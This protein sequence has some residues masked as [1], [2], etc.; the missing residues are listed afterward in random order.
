MEDFSFRRDWKSVVWGPT[1]LVNFFRS[2]AAG[3][4]WFIFSILINSTNPNLLLFPI[5]YFL[6]LLP[7]GLIAGKLGETGVPFAGLFST[8]ISLLVTVGDP[9]VYILYTIKP[10]LIPVE[11]F[12]LFNLRL[13]IFVLQDEALEKIDA[14]KDNSISDE[15]LLTMETSEQ[16][17]F[18]ARK[19]K[20]EIEDNFLEGLKL[21]A[22]KKDANKQ[23]K[24][25]E[26]SLT[27]GLSPQK[28]LIA[29]TFIMSSYANLNNFDKANTEAKIIKDMYG[30]VENFIDFKN[31]PAE[32]L[33]VHECRWVPFYP[34]NIREDLPEEER[35][36]AALDSMKDYH[37]FMGA[38]ILNSY[39]GECY[40]QT[41]NIELA[42]SEF[43][44]GI[45]RFA[46]LVEFAFEV[47]FR[48]RLGILYKLKGDLR[49]AKKEFTKAIEANSYVDDEWFPSDEKLGNKMRKGVKYWL[50]IAE[51][52][53]DEIK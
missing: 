9:L 42:I 39:L 11:K 44:K 30:S 48:S 32:A 50:N 38:R 51:R 18:E 5:V 34:D 47:I 29:R 25:F 3:I 45:D 12:G 41:G 53:L 52:G 36:K 43:K 24:Y 31:N 10:E 4:V 14:S 40:F 46:E 49:S 20:E 22:D 1:L 27:K 13:I 7:I 17:I 15:D 35:K 28:E 16:N 8:F 33:F 21:A 6:V 19:E 37:G 23:V 26:E 2:L